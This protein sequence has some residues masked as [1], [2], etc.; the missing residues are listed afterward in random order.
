ML[1]PCKIHVVTTANDVRSLYA[2][3]THRDVDRVVQYVGVTPLSELFQM[4]DAL[5]NSRWPDTFGKPVTTLEIEVI[6]LTASEKEA[7]QEQR[8]LIMLYHPPCNRRGYHIAP[9]NQH[10]VCNET[11]ETWA[12]I[13]EA[14]TAH[15]LSYSQLHSHLKRKPGYKSVKGKTYSRTVPQQ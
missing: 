7:Y 5:C 6:A 14:A 9:E 13:R 15:G 2:I 8:R 10:V 1:I 4:T 3:Y 12:T 11:G